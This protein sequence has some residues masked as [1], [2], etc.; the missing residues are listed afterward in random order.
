MY[1]LKLSLF[2]LFF[3]QHQFAVADLSNEE[4][5][6]MANIDAFA[7]EISKL[8]SLSGTGYSKFKHLREIFPSIETLAVAEN[9]RKISHLIH[10]KHMILQDLIIAAQ[11]LRDIFVK[12]EISSNHSTES[13]Q[14]T[15]SLE[16]KTRRCMESS[17]YWNKE[18]TVP[19]KKIQHEIGSALSKNLTNLNTLLC[20]SN[21]TLIAIYM[22]GKVPFTSFDCIKE[23]GRGAVDHIYGMLY[24]YALILT[25]YHAICLV[26][27]DLQEGRGRL[28]YA[29]KQFNKKMVYDDM[30]YFNYTDFQINDTIAKLYPAET[31]SD[32]TF[33][34]IG[35]SQASDYS[36]S[37]VSLTLT[38]KLRTI[39]Y[40]HPPAL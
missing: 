18:V 21:N 29:H 31:T 30:S 35:S 15:Q 33:T 27:V 37:T 26:G 10:E 23:C 40:T 36:K 22:T 19:I 38:L 4:P 3:V 28:L 14:P 11:K 32:S 6:E 34:S 25:F 13:P 12:F 20:S 24:D 16:E 2:F 39:Q 7:D 9:L 1:G 5:K 8:I 17:N